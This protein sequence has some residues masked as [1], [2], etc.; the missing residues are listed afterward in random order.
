MMEDVVK[1][2][3]GTAINMGVAVEGMDCNTES[4]N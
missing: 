1:I 3:E 4:E 2:I